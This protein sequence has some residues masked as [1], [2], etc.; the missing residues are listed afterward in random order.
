[1]LYRNVLFSNLQA[2]CHTVRLSCD[3]CSIF[4]EVLVWHYIYVIHICI[5]C[6]SVYLSVC[7]S[8]FLSVCLSVC[9]SGIF[10]SCC[11]LPET[12]H[13]SSLFLHWSGSK[14]LVVMAACA[15]YIHVFLGRPLFL[16]SHD[17][18]SIISFTIT[19]NIKSSTFCTQSLSQ[20]KR[21]ITYLCRFNWLGFITEAECVYS[22]VRTGSL[23]AG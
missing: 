16:F 18:H 20:I 15:P 10:N 14:F 21:A 2:I 5:V 9:L 8:I 22:A 12:E 13:H 23:N 17:I 4:W 6:L 1:M 11:Y 7:L 19:I 3:P